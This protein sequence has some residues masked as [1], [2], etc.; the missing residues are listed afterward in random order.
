M[1]WLGHRVDVAAGES[2]EEVRLRLD[3]DGARSVGRD[4][5]ERADPSRGVGRGHDDASVEH[6]TAGAQMRV[7]AVAD[8]HSGR[9][10][11]D[12]R[13]PERPGKRYEVEYI[14]LGDHWRTVCGSCL[15]PSCLGGHAEM[16]WR[17]SLL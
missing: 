10:V 14:A 6:A 3:G 7:P 11:T 5:A 2:A 17:S 15:A 9:V 4:V 8:L 13:Q 12:H 1:N 16:K